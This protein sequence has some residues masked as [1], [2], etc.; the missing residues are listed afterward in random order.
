MKNNNLQV[1]NNVDSN[2]IYTDLLGKISTAIDELEVGN[3]NATKDI[4]GLS[5]SINDIYT[6]IERLVVNSNKIE[7]NIELVTKNNGEIITVAEDTNLL[8]LNAAIEAAHVGDDGK[9]F[10]VIA[11]EIHKLAA[12]TKDVA[13]KS[14]DNG[15]VIVPVIHKIIN[16]S[17]T[18]KD[19]LKVFKD[20]INSA[21]S[22]T[23][24]RSGQTELLSNSTNKLKELLKNKTGGNNTYLSLLEDINA[25]VK[26]ISLANNYA[27]G[28]LIKMTQAVS[29]IFN[30]IGGLVSDLDNIGQNIGLIKKLDSDIIEIANQTNFLSLNATI[31][32]AHAGSNGK[33]F[34]IIADNV[35]KLAETTKVLAK[36]VDGNGKIIVPAVDSILKDLKYL[37][38]RIRI[39]KD[40]IEIGAE[41]SKKRSNQTETLI[42]STDELKSL[43]KIK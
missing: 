25:S 7:E 30:F 16:S 6:L 11:N 14:S 40:Q 17:K 29:D 35:H 37:K 4:N 33:G 34:S 21:A 19:T 13:Q 10:S 32:A 39:F 28:E 3:S 27:S 41:N 20:K 24:N 43:C 8:S 9:A 36:K 42:T 5:K 15:K 2:E 1:E 18:L 31:E 22:N 12:T 26:E 23:Q 38:E